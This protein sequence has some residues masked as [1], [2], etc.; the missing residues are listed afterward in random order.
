MA[1][2]TSLLVMAAFLQDKAPRVQLVQGSFGASGSG[3]ARSRP[4]SPAACIGGGAAQY[5][6][7]PPRDLPRTAK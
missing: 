7:T 5:H 6:A 2:I 1:H 3:S 4:F